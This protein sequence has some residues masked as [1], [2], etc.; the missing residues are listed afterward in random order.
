MHS[1][2][3][4]PS[5]TP[6][7]LDPELEARVVAWS[8]GELTAPEVAELES[9][10]AQNPAVRAFKAEMDTVQSLLT[11]AERTETTPLR[12]APE[13]RTALLETLSATA[14]ATPPAAD[15]TQAPA[16]GQNLAVLPS[17]R[18]RSASWL[19]PTLYFALPAATA[20][21]LL[22]I[23]FFNPHFGMVRKPARPDPS[24]TAFGASASQFKL[25]PAFPTAG[26]PQSK[27]EKDVGTI[28]TSRL[29]AASSEYARQRNQPAPATASDEKI[30]LNSFNITRAD[31]AAP[32][33]QD[34]PPSV[35]AQSPSGVGLSL[36]AP[37]FA[38]FRGAQAA[39]TVDLAAAEA[40]KSEA[41][42]ATASD[43]LSRPI[44][45]TV[46]ASRYAGSSAPASRPSEQGGGGGGRAGSRPAP[47]PDALAAVN[48]FNIMETA[49]LSGTGSLVA[50]K[51]TGDPALRAELQKRIVERVAEA[52]AASIAQRAK[53]DAVS[54]EGAAPKDQPV[55]LEPFE[56]RE[57]RSGAYTA[58]SALSSSRLASATTFGSDLPLPPADPARILRD[59]LAQADTKLARGTLGVASTGSVADA[60]PAT[61][62]QPVALNGFA[63][64]SFHEAGTANLPAQDKTVSGSFGSGS[65]VITTGGTLA[66]GG[67]PNGLELDGKEQIQSGHF[68]GNTGTAPAGAIGAVAG[69]ADEKQKSATTGSEIVKLEAFTVS[70]E[71]SG[72][73]KAAKARAVTPA[74]KVPVAPTKP[75][76]AK[77]AEADAPRPART[78]VT[79]PPVDETATATTPV[80]TFSLHVSDVS[81]RLAAAALARGEKPDPA[82]I[83][84]EEFYNAFDYGDPSPSVGEK[85]GARIEQAGHPFLPQRN[86]VRVALRVASAGRG[87][88]PLHLTVLLDTSGSMEREDRA[89]SV[90]R[91]FEV[92]VSLL[93]PADRITLV[94]FARTPRLLAENTRGDQAR[95]LLDLIK[96]TPSE[97]GTNLE[98]ALRLGGE[99]AQR[100]FATGAQNRVVLLTD[101]AANL[102]DAEPEKLATRVE[103]FR[104]QGLAFD[105]CGVGL[106]GLDDEILE[107]L[108]RRGDGRYYALNTPADA[109]AGFAQK[110]AGAFRPAAENVKVQVRFNPARVGHYRLI[111]FEQHR[112]REQDFR[113]DTVDAA[114][115]AADENAVALYQVEL[116]P[117]GDGEL[118]ELSVRF[119]DPATK[120][121]VERSWTLPHDPAAPAFARATP[122]LQLAGASALLAEKFRGGTGQTIDLRDL[123]PIAATLRGRYPQDARVQEFVTMIAQA[124]RLFGN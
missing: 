60:K 19:G 17:P 122:T 82:R 99:L 42:S 20:A 47:A 116:L 106:D 46:T 68:Y 18:R 97:G 24:S 113:N 3:S 112:L 6:P 14:S 76:A 48:S 49:T 109:D 53:A 72:S 57:E 74:A 33:A 11:E 37:D 4:P 38:R 61:D 7:P 63:P 110:L 71:P 73:A 108:A 124:R 111:G 62:G 8:A 69:V 51:D 44:E 23:L 22:G 98:E 15:A 123:A 41:F 114:E 30:V 87:A 52:R 105:A 92:L 70:S 86:L 27:A 85:I 45:V 101:G 102:G 50:S 95:T 54:T 40:A 43:I 16:P 35:A 67:N 75:S 117:G 34:L 118:G 28:D 39:P 26:M 25:G 90:H 121:M 88:T 31:P 94:G 119:R 9:L 13:R 55:M 32:S 100:H 65:N 84:A 103:T 81:F 96:R 59:S 1:D 77:P 2:N 107:N 5:D 89:A 104:Q 120:Q 12:L 58:S 115:L 93:G 29:T 21:C 91:A 80:S 56:V 79:P 66:S 10:A 83:R 64:L 78:P 36:P